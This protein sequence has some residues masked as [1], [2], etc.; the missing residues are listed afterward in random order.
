VD[1]A[2]DL[3]DRPYCWRFRTQSSGSRRET[4]AFEDLV[5]GVE[6]LD[7][8]A[9]L[10]DFVV[11]K[12]GGAPSYQLAVVVDDHAM[13]VSEVIRGD[14]LVPSTF[15]QLALY[16]LL[17]WQPPRFGHVPL[18]VGTDGRRLAK[19]HGDTRISVLREQRIPPERLIGELAFTCGLVDRRE[20][21]AAREL[22]GSFRWDRLER[23][24]FVFGEADWARV[25][26]RA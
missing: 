4:A 7:V 15:R 18:V 11:A 26:G 21:V 19:R 10:G 14:D 16:D 1:D 3:G 20:P 6:S 5:R 8:A 22:I 2:A 17:R 12:A 23:R 25:I 13:G 9:D 24:Q